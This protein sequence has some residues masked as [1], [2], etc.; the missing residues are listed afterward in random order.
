MNEEAEN[1]LKEK[2]FVLNMLPNGAN[3]PENPKHDCFDSEREAVAYAKECAKAE[4]SGDDCT[5]HIMRTVAV[6]SAVR[7]VSVKMIKPQR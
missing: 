7:R 4:E 5:Y 3:I 1:L 6:V 2:W